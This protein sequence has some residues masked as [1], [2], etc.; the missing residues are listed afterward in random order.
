M[1]DGIRQCEVLALMN[2][3]TLCGRQ[4]E[5]LVAESWELETGYCQLSAGA[6]TTCPAFN[7]MFLQLRG[8]PSVK[9][10]FNPTNEQRLDKLRKLGNIN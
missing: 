9:E 8:S 1:F 3:P 4:S 6:P 5:E 7:C 10:W 2:D